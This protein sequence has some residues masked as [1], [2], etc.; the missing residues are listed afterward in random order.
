MIYVISK[1]FKPQF[2]IALE[3]YC[4]RTLRHHDK[5]FM[6]WRN[7]PSIILGKFQNTLEEINMPYVR[8]KGIH[9]VRRI[10]GGGAVYH[11]HNNLNYTIISTENKGSEFDFKSFAGPVMEALESLDVKVCLSERNDILI[12]GKKISG[13]AQAYIRGRIM[14]HGCLLFNSELSVLSKALEIPKDEF[15]SRGVKSV[16]SSVDNIYPH[17]A[18]KITIEEFTDCILQQMKLRFPDMEEY[19]FSEEELA[20]VAKIST[21]KFSSWEWNFGHSPKYTIKRKTGFPAGEL[22]V[23][24][25]IKNSVIENINFDGTFTLNNSDLSYVESAL[26]GVKYTREDVREQLHQF[27]TDRYFKGIQIDEFVEA[28]V[29]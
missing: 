26:Q 14:H 12:N 29:D 17:L 25:D 9:V 3:E 2:N 6:L 7:E 8:E 23:C 15:I 24:A 21:E 5:V 16:R 10:S 20:E 1:S 28:I 19:L 22:L 4:F 11:D 13:H 27:S 18:E